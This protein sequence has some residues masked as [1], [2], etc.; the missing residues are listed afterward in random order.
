[1][2]YLSFQGDK[3]HMNA[4]HY[5]GSYLLARSVRPVFKRGL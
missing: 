5:E 3:R 4:G 2:K 1:M